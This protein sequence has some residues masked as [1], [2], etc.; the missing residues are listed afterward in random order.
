[1]SKDSE[2]YLLEILFDRNQIKPADLEKLINKRFPHEGWKVKNHLDHPL[3][4]I[5]S[6]LED[7][8]ACHHK[9]EKFLREKND[10]H[11]VRLTDEAGDEI[12]RRA[13]PLLSSMEQ[14]LRRFIHKAMLEIFGFDW[15]NHPILKTIELSLA[16]TDD[17]EKV[18][19]HFLERIYFDDLVKII[20]TEGSVWPKEKTL[21]VNDIEELLS[22]SNSFEQVK[23]KLEEKIKKISLWDDV[24]MKYF[25]DKEHWGKIKKSLEFVIK[26]RH[27]VMHHRPINL[28]VLK[29]LE[30]RENEL[31]TLLSSAKTE[32]TQQERI[33]AQ[34]YFTD[35]QVIMSH[36]NEQIEESRMRLQHNLQLAA[37]ISAQPLE[38]VRKAFKQ[39]PETLETKDT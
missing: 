9:L 7:V 28:G 4:S 5:T 2:K 14:K 33:E 35:L 36:V 39:N 29:E 8:D 3:L 13:Y 18:K 11:F 19:L 34:K 12:R 24:F 21:S 26:K 31:K 1:M 16:P 25:R 15:S 22:S 23:A 30:E 32:L 38:N 10:L 27:N 17:K 20:E 6:S 37:E